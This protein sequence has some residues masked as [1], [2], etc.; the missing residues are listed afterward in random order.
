MCLKFALYSK[1]LCRSEPIC[2]KRENT[3]TYSKILLPKSWNHWKI[4]V[5]LPPKFKPFWFA[6][7][8]SSDLYL[9]SIRAV[10]RHQHLDRHLALA[11][12]SVAPCA[13]WLQTRVDVSVKI[14]FDFC[15][16]VEWFYSSLSKRHKCDYAHTH[17]HTH[18]YIQTRTHICRHN[19]WH[20]CKNLKGFCWISKLFKPTSVISKMTNWLG[21]VGLCRFLFAICNRLMT[22]LPTTRTAN[23]FVNSDF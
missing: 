4:W 17:T 23:L 12:R 9:A 16:A 19:K 11:S 7:I 10:A 13:R 14:G 8:M 3:G 5:Y 1:H 6:A 20:A 21:V 18:T 22:K 2:L 15:F